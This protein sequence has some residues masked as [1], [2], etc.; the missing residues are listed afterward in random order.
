MLHVVTQY[1]RFAAVRTQQAEEHEDRRGLAGAV[2][3]EQAEG[4]AAR[5]GERD[6]VNDRAPVELLAEVPGFD[7]RWRGRHAPPER[8]RMTRRTTTASS[9]MAPRP[10][11]YRT[12]CSSE[13]WATREFISS[14]LSGL[15]PL[16][17][18]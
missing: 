6:P 1:P 13:F 2:G 10:V 3:A 7:R 5:D 18:R 8:R 16:P 11:K 9:D 14:G 17:S 4:G 15:M 12:N